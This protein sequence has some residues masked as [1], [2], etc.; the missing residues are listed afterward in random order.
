[1]ANE[2]D[3]ERKKEITKMA[4]TDINMANEGFIFD[5]GDLDFYLNYKCLDERYKIA[6]REIKKIQGI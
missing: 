1:M 2:T 3:L 6:I 5:K 4:I